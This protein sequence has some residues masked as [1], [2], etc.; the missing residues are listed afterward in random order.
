MGD[1]VRDR[2]THLHRK[3]NPS[4]IFTRQPAIVRVDVRFSTVYENHES[5]ICNRNATVDG[6][7]FEDELFDALLTCD[8]EQRDRRANP[9]VRCR[10][11]VRAR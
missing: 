11:R 8:V 2:K 7:A 4:I 10:Q 5:I 3:C 1:F 9:Q 6:E